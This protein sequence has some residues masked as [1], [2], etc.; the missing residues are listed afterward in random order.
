MMSKNIILNTDSYKTSHFLQYPK[1]IEYLSS[2]IEARGGKFPSA[3]FF[4]LQ[5]F[6]KEYLLPPITQDNIDEAEAVLKA[7]GVPFNKMGWQYILDEHVGKLPIRIQALDEGTVVPVH[8][9]MVQVVN[10]DPKCAWLSSYIET[11]LLR[12]V[13]YPTTVATVSYRCKQIL[14]EYLEETAD[15]IE[16]LDFKL[17]DFGARGATS[18][19]AAAIGGVAHL[20]NFMGTDT[21][22]GLLAAKKYYNADMAGFSIPAAEHSTIISWGKANEREAYANMLEQ[23]LMP[24]QVVAVVSDSY[25]LW[26]TIDDIWGGELK[27]RIE[28]SGGTL[29]VRPDSGEPIEIVPEAIER[30]MAKF[31]YSVNEKGYRVLPDCIRLIQGDGVGEESIKE[32]LMKMKAQQLSADNVAFGMGGALL[33]KINRD[34]MR[35]AMKASAVCVDGQWRGV[36]KAPVTDMAKRSKQGRLAVI[37]NARGILQTIQESELNGEKNYLDTVFENGELLKVFDFEKIRSNVNQSLI[38]N[39]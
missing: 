10:T 1:G 3:V 29:V 28:Q 33:Q 21:I 13:W 22:S 14:L 36:Y 37:K 25:D 5:M 38:L 2:Y 26:H 7:H 23:F 27:Q 12:A 9:V 35:F 18:E 6:L 17:H 30:L 20:V 4:G 11:A 15:T 24:N 31:G 16:G 32:I 8:N 19:E 39:R 34:T